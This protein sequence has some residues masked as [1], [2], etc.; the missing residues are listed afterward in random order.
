MPALNLSATSADGDQVGPVTIPNAGAGIV[1][2]AQTINA[3]N[4]L[5]SANA[6]MVY[7]LATGAD[8]EVDITASG[9]PA[10]TYK[11][12][13]TAGV[14]YMWDAAS[15]GTNPLTLAGTTVTATTA[16]NRGSSGASGTSGTGATNWGLTPTSANAAT[17][18]M[19]IEVN[20]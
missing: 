8:V 3:L 11:F 1:G 19:Y 4:G 17:L 14:P 13:L 12:C 6:V 7:L 5:I 20:S 2:V 9:G 10:T 18:V 16:T 15:G